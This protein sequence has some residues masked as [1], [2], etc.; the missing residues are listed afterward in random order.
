MLDRRKRRLLGQ[1][2]TP[3]DVAM[4]TLSMLTIAWIIV[5]S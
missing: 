3:L 4:L 2:P 5:T 1:A